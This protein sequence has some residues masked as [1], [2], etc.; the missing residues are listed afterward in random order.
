MV[1][2]LPVTCDDH[3]ALYP[4]LHDTVFLCLVLLGGGGGGVVVPSGTPVALPAGTPSPVGLV[5]V[6]I[7]VGRQLISLRGLQQCNTRPVI[8]HRV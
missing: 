4:R 5:Q 8:V 1:D 7:L 3:F 6:V 2:I